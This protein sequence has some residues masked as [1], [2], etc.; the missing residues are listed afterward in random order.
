MGLR[1][2]SFGSAGVDS[3][4]EKEEVEVDVG[5]VIVTVPLPVDCDDWAAVWPSS[6]QRPSSNSGLDA[7]E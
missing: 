3:A 7:C 5:E 6:S 1:N 4:N 2:L